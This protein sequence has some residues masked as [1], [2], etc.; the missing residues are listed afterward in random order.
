MNNNF[1]VITT[2][3]NDEKGVVDFLNSIVSQTLPP[4]EI[5]VVDGGSKDS[6]I[7]LVTEYAAQSTV[8]VRLICEGRLNIAEAFNIG[9]RSAKNQYVLISCIGNKFSLSMCEDLFTT[10]IES[11][12][13][14]TYGLLL[15][16]DKGSFSRCYNIVFIGN[17]QNIMS[18][19]SVMYKKT[20]FERIG[21]FLESFKYAGEDSEFLKRFDSN[22]LSRRLVDVP[23]VFWET[24]NSWNEYLKK[25]KDYAIAELQH[26]SFFDCMFTPAMRCYYFI[27]ILL[28]MFPISIYFPLFGGGCFALRLLKKYAKYKNLKPA[29]LGESWTIL[30]IFYSFRNIKYIF[31]KNRVKEFVW[32]N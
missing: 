18:N 1:S 22:L 19:R 11:G 6:T 8:P 17:G 27:I 5:V 3:F 20:V 16:I 4:N 26:A 28:L 31:P 30:K 32:R 9:I 15:G 2:S 29:L 10:I 23:T 7:R 25:S 24:P 13:D 14:A 21:F 12:A